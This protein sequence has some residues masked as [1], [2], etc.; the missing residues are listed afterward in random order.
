[1]MRERDD[2]DGPVDL[3]ALYG[4][5][6]G[7]ADPLRDAARWAALAA[8]I[9]ASAHPELRR[10][11]RLARFGLADGVAATLARFAGPALVAA[12]AAV[13]FAVNVARQG[14][15]PDELVASETIASVEAFSDATVRQ[16]L[17]GVESGT[18]WIAEQ[19]APS[20]EDLLR[21][22]VARDVGEQE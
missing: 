13:L 10:R 19:R 1:M 4:A 9:E 2:R 7:A 17:T 15:G 14:D 21:D 5:P 3:R 16:A 11:S 18:S 6:D 22:L 20:T 12:A 8:R